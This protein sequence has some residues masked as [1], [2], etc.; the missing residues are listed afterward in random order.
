M[1]SWILSEPGCQSTRIMVCILYVFYS[2]FYGQTAAWQCPQVRI[3]LSGVV[4]A[5]RVQPGGIAVGWNPGQGGALR[6]PLEHQVLPSAAPPSHTHSWNFGCRDCSS[7]CSPV[8]QLQ[9]LQLLLLPCTHCNN[10]SSC[11][12]PAPCAAAAVILAMVQHSSFPFPALLK[13]GS[14]WNHLFLS[15]K[16]IYREEL[17]EGR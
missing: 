2:V 14:Y 9:E 12:S 15:Q 16:V 4:Q 8:Q 17:L 7:C 11:C 13:N 6:M 1:E 3:C 10:C 5:G